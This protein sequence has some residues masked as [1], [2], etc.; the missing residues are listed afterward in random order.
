MGIQDCDEIVKKTMADFDL[1]QC[2]E[3]IASRL[4]VTQR[5]KLALAMAL[6]GDTNVVLLDEPTA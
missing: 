5:K 6:Q 2:S 4:S 3:L 1:M